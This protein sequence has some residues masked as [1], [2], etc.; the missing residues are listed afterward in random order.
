MESFFGVPT[1]YLAGGAIVVLVMVLAGLGNF[2]RRRP[3]LLSLALRQLPR[4]PAQSALIVVGLMISTILI[5]ASLATGDTLTYSLRSAAVDEIGRL[6]V[7]VTYSNVTALSNP[8]AIASGDPSAQTAVFPRERYD[9]LLEARTSDPVLARDVTGM[10]PTVWLTCRAVNLRSKQG[11][12]AA[13]RGIPPDYDRAFGDL[14]DTTGKPIDLGK[15]QPGD[16]V[17]NR[18]G[19][20]TLEADVGDELTCAG[21][22]GSFRLRIAAIAK[23]VGL[24]TGSTVALT[25]PIGWL[26]SSLPPTR[27]QGV[28][29]P[30]NQ[31]WVTL[32]G[33]LITSAELAPDVATA[34]R[35]RLVDEGADSA[36]RTLVSLPEFRVGLANRRPNLQLRVQRALD[37]LDVLLT[38]QVPAM[39]NAPGAGEFPLTIPKDAKEARQRLDRVLRVGG[40]RGALVQAARDLPDPARGPEMEELLQ[41]ST[42]Y[43]VLP[44]KEQILVG[45]DRA[46]NVLS[47][48][49]LLFSLL[50]V[51]AGLLLVFLIFALLVASRRSELGITR[52]LGASSGDL[53]ALVTL[54]GVAYASLATA[55]GVPVGLGVSRM[56]L[57]ILVWAVDSGWAGFTGSG[58]RVA[59]LAKWD[60]A[61]RS[62]VLAGAV[63]LLLTI[64]TV[65]IA[66]WRVTRVTI[67]TAIRDLPDPPRRRVTRATPTQP[68]QW[69][70]GR[71]MALLREVV[72]VG[73]RRWVGPIGVLLAI[74]GG[75]AE[76]GILF[77]TGLTFVGIAIGFLVRHRAAQRLDHDEARR[78]G[79]SVSAA[80]AGILWLLPFDFQ[81]LLG[82][83]AFDGG[84][85]YFAVGG[86]ASVAALMVVTSLN[87]DLAHRAAASVLTSLGRPAPSIRLA[88][89]Q[90]AR[91]PYRTG[92]TAAMFAVVVFMLTIMQVLTTSISDAQGNRFI[93]YGGFDVSGQTSNQTVL[94]G[95]PPVDDLAISIAGSTGAPIANPVAGSSD[96]SGTG[97]PEDRMRVERTALLG[98][99]PSRVATEAVESQTL[100]PLLA[101]AGTRVTSAVALLQLSSPR[102][103]WGG[104]VG[105]GI[106]EG[107]AR[108]NEIR[109]EN[110]T[111]SYPT[112]RDAWLA[113]VRD[114]SLAI[115][116]SGVL[117]RPELRGRTPGLGMIG[118]VLNGLPGGP[119]TMA[120]Q[121]IWVANPLGLGGA[122]GAKRMKVIGVIDR[123]AS[124]N[125]RGVHIS[126]DTLSFLGQPFR[127][128]LARYYFK[129]VPGAPVGD[130]RAALGVTFFD[131]GLQTVDLDETFRNQTGPVL[132]GSG[133]L[134]LFVGL[135]LISGVAALAVV[136]TRSTLERRQQIGMLR[137]VGATRHQVT[138][139]LL[140][141]G[142]VVVVLGS[143]SGTIV[144]L[145]LCRNVFAVQFFDRFS[146]GS[147]LMVVPWWQLAGTL[148]LASGF[149]LLAT[150][151]P[152]WRGAS[153]PPVAAIRAE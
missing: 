6:D 45:A 69:T 50:S 113:V 138:V 91:F 101:G 75:F 78:L 135:G 108:T 77:T 32:R 5:T 21:V 54:E 14:V 28:R 41:R 123:R 20:T 23:A 142:M 117:P 80:I 47:T 94:L 103:A 89:A 79:F 107:F 144:G 2:A 114:P 127:P 40:V 59:E 52:A 68:E 104:Y 129:L 99:E 100:R 43:L 48:I 92:M 149:A 112:D 1:S 139:S 26:Q 19:A 25:V 65:S 61:P 72:I 152:A 51:A 84:I 97:G 66:A 42:G 8:T 67:V 64:A 106:D 131:D 29:D 143:V 87:G 119:G 9:Q 62:I 151:V 121:D 141:E 4:R 136:A 49:F 124:S 132:L 90:V 76:R 137:A 71:I 145:W 17:V 39:R 35:S 74:Y 30:I 126:M 10:M 128:A 34:L 130:A 70:A 36:L 38:G 111:S 150:L 120:A 115:V 95:A 102:P 55:A 60:A 37:E 57:S 44:I 116:D 22:S 33:S 133:L 18:A 118:F 24:G 53:V 82:L 93:A 146:P 81:T 27:T 63:G 12:G 85:E 11:A 140:L 16:A 15:F 125:F 109:L 98:R 148:A 153:V 105:A 13:I 110:R 88:L 31:I 3:I 83:G 86:L 147:I 7:V 122:V 56:L 58:A 134:Q 73:W 46:G 96:A